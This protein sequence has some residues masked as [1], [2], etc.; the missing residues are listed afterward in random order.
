M[1][2]S[3]MKPNDKP[4]ACL[5][6]LGNEL[7]GTCGCPVGTQ[8]DAVSCKVIITPGSVRQSSSH[9]YRNEKAKA[10]FR[11]QYMGL[12]FK[13]TKCHH[14]LPLL[15]SLIFIAASSSLSHRSVLG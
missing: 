7:F 14:R 9:R 2:P 11:L 10:C 5:R 15:A 12:L 1:A 6:P 8:W 13:C 3:L 4:F